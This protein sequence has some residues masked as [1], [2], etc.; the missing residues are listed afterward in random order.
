MYDMDLH[1]WIIEKHEAASGAKTVRAIAED[2]CVAVAFTHSQ[3]IFHRGLKPAN[4]LLTKSDA[5]A[6]RRP[7][8]ADFGSARYMATSVARVQDMAASG[9]RCEV[10]TCRVATP[11]YV[12]PEA[13][14]PPHLY[15]YPSDVWALGIICWKWNMGSGCVALPNLRPTTN[16]S[17]RLGAYAE[18]ASYPAGHPTSPIKQRRRVSEYSVSLS[19]VMSGRRVNMGRCSGY[20]RR[21][22]LN[23]VHVNAVARLIC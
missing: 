5:Q 10:M 7:V 19:G 4:V 21:N 13:L 15:S 20:G 18:R 22:L 6:T 9:A 1:K 23:L 17:E 14:L 2:F 11:G 8:L 3:R 16:S 12:S